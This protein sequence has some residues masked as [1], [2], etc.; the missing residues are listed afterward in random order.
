MKS[1]L[2][3]LAL[4]L[5]CTLM[6]ATL[7]AATPRPAVVAA[8]TLTFSLDSSF[9]SQLKDQGIS[10]SYIGN[11]KPSKTMPE[12]QVQGGVV[13]LQNATG[14]IQSNGGV[15]FS[16]GGF[17]VLLQR[18]ALVNSLVGGPQITALVTVDGV[19]VGRLAVATLTGA[20]AFPFPLH[21][22][23]ISSGPITFRVNK[24]FAAQLSRYFMLPPEVYA[25]MLGQVDLD[26]L[27][28]PQE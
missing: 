2:R 21:M 20:S 7:H 24:D 28:A 15:R 22:G 5:T 1:V 25:N 6:G 9:S 26:L 10:I 17:S 19:S 18:M 16:I 14:E 4:A 3:T 27:L 23:Q 12:F 8:G 11:E 13:D